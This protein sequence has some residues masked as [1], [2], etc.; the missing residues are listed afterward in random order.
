MDNVL[1]V[2]VLIVVG[3]IYIQNNPQAKEKPLYKRLYTFVDRC[4]SAFSELMSDKSV[5]SARTV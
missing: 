4:G 5:D 1:I 2:I 3:I